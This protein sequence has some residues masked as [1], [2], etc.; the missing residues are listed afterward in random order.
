[1]LVFGVRKVDGE[2]KKLSCGF[3]VKCTF[4]AVCAKLC[5]LDYLNCA[6]RALCFACSAY[7]TLVDVYWDGFAVFDF[8]DAYGAS[9][10]AGFASGASIIVYYYF[11][12]VLY[13]GKFV[14]NSPSKI[15]VFRLISGFLH[16][17]SGGFR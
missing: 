11:Y 10:C 12:H 9:V 2:M 5:L 6:F 17:V 4:E 3:W 14:S 8:V 1:L 16:G 13:L 15:K 7:K